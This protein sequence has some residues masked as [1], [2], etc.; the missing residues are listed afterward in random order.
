MT[1]QIQ[2]C[3]EWV[4]QSQ[5]QYDDELG[6]IPWYNVN[7]ASQK[8]SAFTGTCSYVH[9]KVEFSGELVLLHDRY[10]GSVGQLWIHQI[11]SHMLSDSLRLIS[12]R[13]QKCRE[14]PI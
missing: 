11:P 5:G 12:V 14:A 4:L 7:P 1:I 13:R 2:C 8:E 10:R 3:A 9:E 6:S